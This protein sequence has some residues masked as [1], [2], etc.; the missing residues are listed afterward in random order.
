MKQGE[1]SSIRQ[2]ATF[3]LCA[4]I[5]EQEFRVIARECFF[6]NSGGFFTLKTGKKNTT[7]D[8][9]GR[10]RRLVSDAVQF[11]AVNQKRAAIIAVFADDVCAHLP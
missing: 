11:F 2:R 4:K 9:G 8:L 10:N 1:D 3:D 6:Y 7:F 5:R